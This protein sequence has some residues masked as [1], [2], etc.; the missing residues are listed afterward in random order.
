MWVQLVPPQR[1][2]FANVITQEACT[3]DGAV[4]VQGVVKDLVDRGIAE[5]SDGAKVIH[6]KVGAAWMQLCLRITHPH[7]GWHAALTER[8]PLI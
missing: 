2:D 1:P 3:Y 7:V 4:R 8:V 6:N 5:D